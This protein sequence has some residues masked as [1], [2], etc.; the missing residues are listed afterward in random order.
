MGSKG[1]Y[2]LKRRSEAEVQLAIRGALDKLHTN[3]HAL[4]EVFAHEIAITSKLAYYLQRDFSDWHVD[5]EYN[6][7][8]DKP[9]TVGGEGRR[10]DI[11]IHERLQENN[12][13]VIELKKRVS[14]SSSDLAQARGKLI[15]L[16]NEK[17]YDFAY[18]LVIGDH[19]NDWYD[20]E[21]V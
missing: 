16:K 12:H 5:I 15:A 8:I 18:L 17:H 13:V 9:K 3:D 14:W 11:I 6:R 21:E 2:I 4:L 10:P 7:D 20:L 1:K 19:S